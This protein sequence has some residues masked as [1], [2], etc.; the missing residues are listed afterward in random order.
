MLGAL[1]VD[2]RHLNNLT[3]RSGHDGIDLTVNCAADA[4]KHHAAFRDSGAKGIAQ[5]RH[6]N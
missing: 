1:A 3:F 4:D 5:S 2:Q 6:I